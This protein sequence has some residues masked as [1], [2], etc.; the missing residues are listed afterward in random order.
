MYQKYTGVILKK[1]PLGEA[2]DLLTI[3]TREA[4]KLR[5]K[6]VGSR[7]IRSRLAGILQSLN[8][9]DFET[10]GRHSS[11]RSPGRDGLPVLISARARAINSYLRE[12][13]KKFAYALVGIETLYRLASDYQENGEAYAGLVQ[14]LQDLGEVQEEKLS[15]RRFQLHLLQISGFRLPVEQCLNCG[16]RF[17]DSGSAYFASEKGGFFCPSCSH[18]EK[19]E[20]L[21]NAES[22]GQLQDLGAGRMVKE[23][24]PETELTIEGFLNYVLEREIKSNGFLRTLNQ[25]A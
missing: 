23:L 21:L 7:K 4:G 10:A 16:V 18:R 1:Y 13:L 22:I 9:I 15:V 19:I 25:E 12:N 14:F 5:V 20:V 8:E 3:Y 24:N 17:P 2:D 6:A 11:R